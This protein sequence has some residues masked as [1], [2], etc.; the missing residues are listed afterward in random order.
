VTLRPLAA[1]KFS[2]TLAADALEVP[3]ELTAL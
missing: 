3:C 2:V 1:G